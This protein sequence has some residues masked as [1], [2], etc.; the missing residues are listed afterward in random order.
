MSASDSS[1]LNPLQVGMLGDLLSLLSQDRQKAK[2]YADLAQ[3]KA[4][5][6]VRQD[7]PDLG[8]PVEGGDDMNLFYQSPITVPKPEPVPPSGNLLKMAM[9]GLLAA[10]TGGLGT[11]LPLWFLLKP[12]AATITSESKDFLLRFGTAKQ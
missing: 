11:A 12:A 4:E 6:Q 1:N 2:A 5:A 10:L 7:H 9:V 3:R 8:K